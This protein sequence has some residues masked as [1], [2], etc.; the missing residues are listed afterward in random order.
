M[1]PNQQLKEVFNPERAE[2]M[3]FLVCS[4]LIGQLQL[5]IICHTVP[6]VYILDMLE[7][8]EFTKHTPS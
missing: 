5:S 4:V 2:S 1:H 3:R 8:C 7:C 6:E